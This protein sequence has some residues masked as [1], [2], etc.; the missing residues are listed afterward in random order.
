MKHFKTMQGGRRAIIRTLLFALGM[1]ISLLAARPLG[2]DQGSATLV[3]DVRPDVLLQAGPAGPWS[4]GPRA[5]SS[6]PSRV[7]IRLAPGATGTLSVFSGDSASPLQVETA[8]GLQDV[9]TAGIAVRSYSR[10]GAYA[11]PIV[12]HVVQPV[13]APVSVGVRLTSSD[14]AFSSTTTVVLPATAP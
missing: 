4:S 6:I 8:N 7:V 1:W 10:S 13:G 12:I 2:A 11:E 9:S 3:L 14:G 5:S